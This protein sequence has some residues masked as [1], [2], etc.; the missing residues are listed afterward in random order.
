MLLR[1]QT[2]V[3]F[4]LCFHR[5]APTV[6]WL[7]LAVLPANKNPRTGPVKSMSI[8]RQR[9]VFDS[10]IIV[11]ILS[12]KRAPEYN[13]HLYLLLI[14]AESRCEAERCALSCPVSSLPLSFEVPCKHSHLHTFT[15]GTY[16]CSL[17][18]KC[19]LR[20]V[21]KDCQI[22]CAMSSTYLI[23]M[24]LVGQVVVAMSNQPCKTRVTDTDTVV[25]ANGTFMILK[26][27]TWLKLVPVPVLRQSRS[28]TALE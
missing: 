10:R 25:T 5:Q 18:L 12:L 16:W 4:N 26:H 9:I 7:E 27:A 2:S 23:H 20:S 6:V 17:V 15:L 24:Y 13:P 19:A 8:L 21:L 3:R 28:N 14:R 1:D 11:V 22:S